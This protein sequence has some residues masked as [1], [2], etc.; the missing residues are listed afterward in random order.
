MA[1]PNNGIVSN[2]A[3]AVR[4]ASAADAARTFMTRVYGW[5]LGGLAVT[6]L[7]AF[8]VAATPALFQ[9]LLPWMRP[10]MF[11]QL[12]VVLAFTFLAHRVNAALA[13]LLFL[14]YSLLTGVTFSVLL[15]VFPLGT[16]AQAFFVTAGSFGALSVYGTVTR[17]DLSAWT[18]FLFMGLV[19]VLLAGVVNVFVGSSMLGFVVSAASVVVFAGL[20][21]WDT[22]KLRQ[23][24]A[25][26]GSSSEGSLAIRGALTLYLDFINLFLSLLQLLGRRR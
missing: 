26:S 9:A 2:D 12:G 20:T 19:G 13:A 24:H 7:T 22:Q 5:M 11:L 3:Y 15:H 17:R 6:G 21:A 8:A 16:L 4:G 23:L 1:W 14:G 25:A 10:L 18:T